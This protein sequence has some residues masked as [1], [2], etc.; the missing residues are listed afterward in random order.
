MLFN[1]AEF[2]VF[3]PIVFIL[4][5]LSKHKYRWIILLFASYYFYMAWRPEYI[6]LIMFSTFIDYLCSIRMGQVE[7]KRRKP[8]LWISILTNLGLL[9]TFKYFTLFGNSVESVIN[10]WDRDFSFISLSIILPMGISFYTFQTLSYSIDVYNG[11]IQPEKHIGIFALFVT[12]FP[13]LVAGPIERA[14]VLL[15]QFK[16]RVKFDNNRVSSG[17][18]LMTWGL[19]KKV[20]IADRIAPIVNSI[21][22]EPS[23]FEGVHF[24]IA[25]VLFAYQIYCDF[26]G[27]SD[28]AIGG[29]RV[30]GFNLSENFRRPYYSKTISEFWKRWHISLSTWFRD[31]LYIPLGGNRVIK[32]RR[33]Y[34][35]LITFLVSGLWHGANWTFVI[36]GGLHGIYLVIGLMTEESRNK[37]IDK[38]KINTK[39]TF[40]NFVQVILTFCLVSFAW[41]FFRANSLT[42]AVYIISE[43]KI[44]LIDIQN[45]RLVLAEMGSL[46]DLMIVFGLIF[47]LEMIHSIQRKVKLIYFVS[48]KPFII[49]WGLYSTF[50]FIIVLLGK[51]GSQDFIY[52]QF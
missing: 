12:F 1:S 40:Y 5:F 36:W 46:V 20:V 38:L 4:Y 11:K 45:I 25:T 21:Y 48:Q 50:V 18:K 23:S 16:K 33:Y 10:L 51:W 28:M 29:A 41:I 22:N 42:D 44:S 49:R 24:I 32:W 43:L 2:I 17:L 39:G 34:N 47:F 8:F 7:K 14:S 31:Y 52:F 3:F 13:Q 37:F 30:L 6:I 35:L 27:Y 15:P 26:S 9:F 19:F